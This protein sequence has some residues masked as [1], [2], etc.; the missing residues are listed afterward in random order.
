VAVIGPHRVVAVD[1]LIYGDK[2][3]P[4]GREEEILL[5]PSRL[6]AIISSNCE[7]GPGRWWQVLLCLPSCLPARFTAGRLGVHGRCH[8]DP[9]CHRAGRLRCPFAA[10]PIPSLTIQMGLTMR[11]RRVASFLLVSGFAILLAG[12]L[13]AEAGEAG[14]DQV[15]AITNVAVVDVIGKPAQPGQTVL[16]RGS[17]IASVGKSSEL[18]A[19]KG[20]QVVDGTGKFLIPGLWDMHVHVGLPQFFGLFLANGVTGIRQMHEF[21]MDSVFKWREEIRKGTMMG[22]RMVAAGVLIDGAGP[23]WPGSIVAANAKEGRDAVQSLKKHGA[24]FIKVYT[25][26]SRE[27]YFAIA[28]EAKKEGLPFAG[29]VPESVSAAE[30]SDAG[31]KSMEHLY[32]LSLACSSK[33]DEIRKTI[34]EAMSK[35]ENKEVGRLLVRAQVQSLDTYDEQKAQRLFK[36]LA[37]DRTWQVPTFTVLR[38]MASLTDPEFTADPRIKYM[39]VF[40]KEFW[41]PKGSEER[42]KE[43]AGDAKKLFKKSLEMVRTLHRAGVPLL[44]GTDCPNPYCFPGF[45]LHDELA[46]FVEAGL[47]PA[48]ALQCATLNPAKYLG[49]EDSLGTIEKGKIADLVLLDGN[50]LDNIRNTQKIYAVVSN[51]RYLPQPTL[52][53]MLADVEA[54][55]NAGVKQQK[56]APDPKAVPPPRAGQ[57]AASGEEEIELSWGVQVPMRDGVKLNATVYKPKGEPAPVPVIFTLTPYIADTYHDRA[58]YF[59]RNGYAFALVDA[60]GRGNSGGEF[61]PFANEGRD[62]HDVVEWLARQSW[63]NGKVAMWGG[64]YAGFDQWSTLKESP[65]HLTTIVPA[66]AA[67]PGVDFPSRN[68]MFSSYI[69]RWLTFTSGKALNQKLFGETSL[70]NQMYAERFVKHIPFEKLDTLAGNPSPHFQNWLKHRTPDAYLDG[71]APSAEQY[72]RM[73]TPILTITGHYD[74][75]QP[76]AMA[77]YHRHMQHGSASGRERH[78]LIIGPWDHAG[79]RTP[80]QDVGG[81]TFGKASVVDLNKLHKEWYDWTMKG[82]KKP[83]F[84]E[85]RVAYYVA[86]AEAWKFSDSLEAIPTKPVRLYLTSPDGEA[87]DVFRSGKLDSQKPGKSPPAKYVYDPLDIRPAEIEKREVK[88]WLTDQ[89]DTLNL[90]GNGL[91]YHS[92]PFATATE[93]TGYVKLVAWI[94]LDVPDTDFRVTLYEIKPDGT[95]IALTTD[96]M[97]ARYRH[98]LRKEQLVKPGEINRYEFASFMFFSRR[99]EK[100]SRLRLVFS[101]PNSIFGE[102]N[103][104]SGGDVATETSKDARTAHVTLYQDEEHASYLEIPV[105]QTT[106]AEKSAHQQ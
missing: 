57:Q 46:L 39:P 98:S 53:K 75:D 88:N 84:L 12:G 50:P 33:E 44:A 106:L 95:S 60:R 62:G 20:A 48:E 69:I 86:G 66:A 85:K 56:P 47:T 18:S 23:I 22:P 87:N 83:A 99:L 45:S 27:A 5:K 58:M 80:V 63:C 10:P 61:E 72:G 16:I 89:R 24:D 43:M 68:G 77:Y 65:P 36:R 104:N 103:Y 25:K 54:F 1:L 71:M 79:T 4:R 38:A 32:G 92:E 35:L 82:G 55:A 31:Q 100:G 94:T 96:Q 102:K 11:P 51:G 42:R 49:M 78:F 97:R 91:V 28:D 64:S 15:L 37:D 52:Q 26:L 21:G 70:W 105:V 93:M 3:I 74:G 29:H 34:V 2:P 81:L 6:P 90:L 17:R 73:E 13:L 9:Q 7:H 41:H 40:F 76:G 67:H 8:A 14:K 59:A 19:P 101:S 30:A